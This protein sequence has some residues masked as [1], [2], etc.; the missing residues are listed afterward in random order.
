MDWK[1]GGGGCS[2]PP[3]LML[4]LPRRKVDFAPSTYQSREKG[5]LFL[6]CTCNELPSVTVLGRSFSCTAALA[7]T[8]SSQ[9][10]IL[11][12]HGDRGREE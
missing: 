11:G 2:T 10:V 5:T 12:Q 1:L 6:L 3:V 4:A 9:E 8:L 7:P